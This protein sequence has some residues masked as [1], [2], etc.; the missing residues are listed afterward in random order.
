MNLKT[1]ISLL[2]LCVEWDVRPCSLLTY[3]LYRTSF[4]AKWYFILVIASF[5]ALLLFPESY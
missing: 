5:G 4:F 2:L 3:T 1:K